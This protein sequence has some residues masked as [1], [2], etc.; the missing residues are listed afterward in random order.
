MNGIPRWRDCLVAVAALTWCGTAQA[1]S[2]MDYNPNVVVD[3]SVLGQGSPSYG[4]TGYGATIGPEAYG[5]GSRGLLMPNTK[6]PHS[7][8]HVPAPQLAPTSSL[9][10][11]SQPTPRA[12]PVP[13][14]DEIPVSR[15]E[16]A[17]PKALPAAPAPQAPL[18]P[19]KAPDTPMAKPAAPVESPPAP[20][21]A[22]TR[23]SPP[24]TPPAA[25]VTTQ[26]AP[27]PPAPTK[28]EVKSVTPL[29]PAPPPPP[30]APGLTPPTAPPAAPK[31]VSVPPAPPTPTKTPE[32]VAS[33]TEAP[34]AVL[35]KAVAEMP[36]AMVTFKGEETRLSADAR[37]TLAQTVKLLTDSPSSRL[38][39]RAFAGGEGLSASRARRVS[40]SRA[41]AVRSF[42]MDNGVASNRID[43]RALGD[44]ST[45]EPMNRV[46]LLP[47]VR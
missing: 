24:P 37:T 20:A 32:V 1:Q 43:V 6:Y 13:E 31:A 7:Q 42:L 4:S 11:R 23:I 26:P 16:V 15:L 39:L 25:P 36:K 47:V 27:P 28:P 46:D 19:P 40:L 17:P 34:A 45:E 3:L 12:T 44:K 10:A 18:A 33:L 35:D 14:D 29:P 30:K 8:L 22:P 21:S 41:L 9:A 2:G 5:G 38:Q